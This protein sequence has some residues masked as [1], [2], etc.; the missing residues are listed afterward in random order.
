MID[1]KL[2]ATLRERAAKQGTLT[3]DDLRA[4]LP[5]ETMSADDLAMVVLRLED[6]GVSLE[7]TDDLLGSSR[8]RTPSSS[9]TPVFQ[10]P[11]SQAPMRST[12]QH[13]A[14]PGV[15]PDSYA[16]Q[17]PMQAPASSVGAWKFV[18]AAGAIVA[19]G[20]AALLFFLR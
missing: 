4:V 14:A 8:R 5:I 18:A 1:D 15:S 10:L 6:A 3:T 16:S 20:A 2:L 9:Q 7:V 19:L 13:A 17:Q 11:G 12:S